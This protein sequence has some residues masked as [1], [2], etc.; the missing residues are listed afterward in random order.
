MSN[1]LDPAALRYFF[2]PQFAVDVAMTAMSGHPDLKTLERELE[3]S[4]ES[5]RPHLG[6][7][8]AIGDDRAPL[9]GI[10]Q[11][12]DQEQQQQGR[13][14]VFQLHRRSPASRPHKGSSRSISLATLTPSQVLAGDP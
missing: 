4:I 1:L 11:G 10:G 13:Q 14:E 6:L 3:E 8:L 9:D 12:N 7:E 2:G 5:G